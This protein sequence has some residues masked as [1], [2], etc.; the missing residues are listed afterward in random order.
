MINIQRFINPC[1]GKR[2]QEVEQ[3]IREWSE[4]NP[5]A[6]EHDGNI[7]DFLFC[8]VYTD[9]ERLLYNHPEVDRFLVAQEDNVCGFDV[10][11]KEVKNGRKRTHWI[12]YILPQMKGL[13]HSKMSEYWGIASREEAEAYLQEE[14]LRS[15]LIEM[16]QAILDSDKTV[17]EIFEKDAVKVR[18]CFKLFD[19]IEPI[20]EIRKVLSRYRWY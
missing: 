1:I 14:T 5:I 19:S 4:K 7:R 3:K 18:S 16:A 8:D 9:K 20:P 10:A 17:Y 2:K 11:L 6:A 15:H 12:W 13:G